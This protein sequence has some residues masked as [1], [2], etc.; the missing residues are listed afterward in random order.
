MN[1]KRLIAYALALTS[2]L[3]CNKK[4]DILPSKDNEI[5]ETIENTNYIEPVTEETIPSEWLEDILPETNPT[6]ET[7]INKKAFAKTNITVH[8]DNQDK[9]IELSQYDVVTILNYKEEEQGLTEVLL[10]NG[11][12]IKVDY[13]LF[14][15]LPE[16]YVEVDISKQQLYCYYND[17]LILVADVVTGNPAIG[18][19][20]GTNLGYTETN[21]KLYQTYLMGN[22]YV[23]IFIS[24]NSDGEGFHNAPWRTE[25]GGEIYKTNGS[26]GCVNMK[27]E[28]VK[29]LDEYTQN[30]GTKVLIHK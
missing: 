29:I 17:E 15:I 18:T 20:P 2:L 4:E 1:K 23:D 9:V 22:S 25:F 27:Y 26:H 3:G 7:R 8:I 6:I 16:T 24:F 5:T 19:T 10:E 11:E 30:T 13:S 28:D 14:Q 21:G 12:I